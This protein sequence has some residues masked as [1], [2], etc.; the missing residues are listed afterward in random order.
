MTFETQFKSPLVWA[1]LFN[2][3]SKQWYIKIRNRILMTEFLDYV[4]NLQF[5]ANLRRGISA[6]WKIKLLSHQRYCAQKNNSEY[7]QTKTTTK[8]GK[9]KRNKETKQ[10]Q[11]RTLQDQNK[12]E[13]I[14]K[15]TNTKTNKIKP[16]RKNLKVN[17]RINLQ[18]APSTNVESGLSHHGTQDS[19]ANY[20]TVYEWSANRRPNMIL[21]K[22][23]RLE[24]RLFVNLTFAEALRRCYLPDGGPDMNAVQTAPEMVNEDYY[25]FFIE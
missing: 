23:R 11:R 20:H 13:S 8:D 7:K 14:T 19:A 1:K 21:R 18:P 24:T 22:V 25:R 4:L 10:K 5:T 9:W 16:K 15:P 17:L 2:S 6:K 3:I 12:T